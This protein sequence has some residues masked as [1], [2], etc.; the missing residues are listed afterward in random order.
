M[1][2]GM[3]TIGGLLKAFLPD[4]TTANNLAIGLLAIGGGSVAAGG[5]MMLYSIS[6]P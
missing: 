1:G 3:M 4:N 2:V 6:L 5:G